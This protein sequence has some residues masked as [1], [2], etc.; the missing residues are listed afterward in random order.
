MRSTV[1]WNKDLARNTTW[2]YQRCSRPNRRRKQS[3][4]GG[5]DFYF[6][7]ALYQGGRSSFYE[8]LGCDFR[9]W[10]KCFLTH[11]CVDQESRIAKGCN[12]I[13]IFQQLPALQFGGVHDVDGGLGKLN[14]M[15]KVNWNFTCY[16]R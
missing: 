10:L 3:G 14:A 8:F 9:G 2:F 7:S 16:T 6:D 4:K 1:I 5:Q 12:E 15:T 11:A 13:H